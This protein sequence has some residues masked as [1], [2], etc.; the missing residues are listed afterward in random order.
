MKRLLR[1]YVVSKCAATKETVFLSEQGVWFATADKETVMFTVRI[2][3]GESS[4]AS[5]CPKKTKKLTMDW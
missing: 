5:C 3:A 2:P 1:G 4:G